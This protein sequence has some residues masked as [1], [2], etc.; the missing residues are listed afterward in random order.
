MDI[1]IS[2]I[3][4]VY[5]HAENIE[6]HL[7]KINEQTFKEKEVIVVAE[8]IPREVLKEYSQIGFPTYLVD[9]N[10][11]ITN[12][13]AEM[14]HGRYVMIWNSENSLKKDALDSLWNR[15]KEQNY[16]DICIS[17]GKQ[18]IKDLS[19]R[20]E[21]ERV[22]SLAG[23]SQG[24]ML[25]K[26]ETAVQAEWDFE[27]AEETLTALALVY[28]DRIVLCDDRLTEKTADEKPDGEEVSSGNRLYRESLWLRAE[29]KRRGVFEELERNFINVVLHYYLDMLENFADKNKF[30]QNCWKTE[31]Y[32]IGI[33]GHTKGYFYDSRDFEK[34][35]ELLEKT[36]EEIWEK[37]HI[38]NVKKALLPRVHLRDWNQENKKMDVEN[39]KV[40]VI[41][42]FYN[43]ENYIEECICSVIGQSFQ[44]LEILCVDDGSTDRSAEIVKRFAKADPRIRIAEQKNK[45][46]SAA[47]NTALDLATGKY[48]YFM[49][50][51]DI[52]KEKTLEYCVYMA[53]EQKLDMVLFSAEEFFEN[54]TMKKEKTEYEGYYNRYGDYG[55]LISGKDFFKRAVS[56]GEYKPAVVLYLVKKEVLDRKKL[57]FVEGT[58]CEDNLFSFQ[59]LSGAERVRYVNGNF[60][61]RR[62]REK[63]VMTGSG[64]IRLA[65]SYYTVL[66]AMEKYAEDEQYDREYCDIL[67][68]QMERMRDNACRAVMNVEFEDIARSLQKKPLTDWM[69]FYFYVLSVKNIKEVNE[70]HIRDLK[71]SL[72]NEK[73]IKLKQIYQEEQ[74]NKA[75]ENEKLKLMQSKREVVELKEELGSLQKKYERQ[76][77]E[78][79]KLSQGWSYRIGR[80][81]TWI[82]R[83]IK[84]INK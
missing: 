14:I 78:M 17:D 10:H 23:I 75:F 31:F 62:L 76:K 40:T 12:G 3:L 79:Q 72:E 38:R 83:K 8:K 25:I 33:G 80:V 47:R 19:V 7:K 49:D 28:A 13:L 59:C 48:I 65:Y 50:S 6:K 20:E 9:Q 35:L 67:R 61:R 42:P 84:R 56:Y 70:K 81:I 46:A 29:L 4:P 54:E 21:S 58:V 60:Y 45:G 69:D 18:N 64:G 37:H 53:E 2:V 51:D 44:N 77:D 16:P 71:K 1:E 32:E 5:D 73:I 30:L 24:C 74:L 39:T 34:L 43:V 11:L 57:R 22:L 15:V 63:S 36:P 55:G 68:K 27:S 66:K 52:L 26:K 82:P 41:I